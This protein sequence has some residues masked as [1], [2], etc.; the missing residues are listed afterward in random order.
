MVRLAELYLNYAEACVECN[1]LTEAKKYLNYVRE[2][3]GIPKVEVSWDGI[4]ELTQD[5]LREIVHQ[6][7]LIEL[8]LENHQGT[9]TS[10]SASSSLHDYIIFFMFRFQKYRLQTIHFIR[11][12]VRVI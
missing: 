12:I 4:A 7:R 1:D 8:Y 5:K 11:I 10:Q 6:E 2:R 3:A 9:Y